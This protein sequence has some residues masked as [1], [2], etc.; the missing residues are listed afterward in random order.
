MLATFTPRETFRF[1]TDMRL[2]NMSDEQ[3]DEIVQSM[4]ESLGLTKCS[5]TYIGGRLIRGIS[6]GERKRT[7]VGV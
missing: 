1:I 6:G 7:S 2:A 4:I 5:E 3:K